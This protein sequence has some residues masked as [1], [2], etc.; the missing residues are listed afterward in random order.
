M[1]GS[2]CLRAGALMGGYTG[3]R[4]SAWMR[5]MESAHRRLT[6]L[7]SLAGDTA[8]TVLAALYAS[9]HLFV[10]QGHGQGS[11]AWGLVLAVLCAS[12]LLVRS[13]WPL[14]TLLGVGAFGTLY[15]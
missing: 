15:L 4:R 7:P 13:R 2:R 6:T 8:L 14:A 12:S 5:M 1:G 10:T 9:L 3:R 11:G